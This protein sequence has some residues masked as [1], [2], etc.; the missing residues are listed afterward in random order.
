M[1]VCMCSGTLCIGTG[2]SKRCV[3]Q[4]RVSLPV[5]FSNAVSADRIGM[6]ASRFLAPAAACGVSADCSGMAAQRLLAAAA[7]C[8][9]LFSAATVSRTSYCSGCMMVA[10]S[11]LAADFSAFWRG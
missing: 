6:A 2:A 11:A 3:L 7:A 5:V 4:Y 8:V 1:V 10:K 9:I